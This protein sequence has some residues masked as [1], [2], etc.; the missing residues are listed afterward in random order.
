MVS[1][2]VE[3]LVA[4]TSRVKTLKRPN[5]HTTQNLLR[6]SISSQTKVIGKSPDDSHERDTKARRF[7]EAPNVFGRLHP[8]N[9]VLN[10]FVS[11]TTRPTTIKTDGNDTA[12]FTVS[13]SE[14]LTTVNIIRKHLRRYNT[15]KKA[16]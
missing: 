15:L 11:R 16:T 1:N 12:I 6:Q 2:H 7:I 5:Q 9:F 8:S 13:S 10:V 3:K 4:T 14:I